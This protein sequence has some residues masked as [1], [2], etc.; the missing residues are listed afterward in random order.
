MLKVVEESGIVF[1][2]TD[3]YHFYPPLGAGTE[4]D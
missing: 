1:K 2:V 4:N 3:N